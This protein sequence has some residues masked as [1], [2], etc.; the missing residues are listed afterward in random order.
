MTE[1]SDTALR[2]K[3][4]EWK[5]FFWVFAALLLLLNLGGAS[6]WGSEG[7]WAEIV[8]EMF[9]T[10]DFLHPRINWE[11][12]FDKPLVSYWFIAA[13]AWLNGGVV[14]EFLS[15]LPSSLAA[16]AALYG[17]LSIGR[18]LWDEKTAYRAGWI[19]LTAY[20]FSFWGRTAAADMENVAF[21]ILA[22]AWYL[23]RRERTDFLSYA[24]FWAICAVGGQTKGL[25]AIVLPAL[26]A[27][28]DMLVCGTWKRH[29]NVQAALAAIAGALVYFIP[30]ILERATR[31]GEY[32]SSGLSLVFREN[33]ERFFKPF[34]HNEPFYVYFIYVPQLFLPWTPLLLLAIAW[35]GKEWRR[36][37]NSERWLCLSA[38]ATFAIFTASGSRR[39]YYILP[40]LPFCALLCAVYFKADPEGWQRKA[41]EFL[42]KAFEILAVVAAALALALCLVWRPLTRKLG[43]E[44]PLILEPFFAIAG[45]GLLFIV[46]ALKLSASKRP[47]N[48]DRLMGIAI[49][50]CFA[51]IMSFG[52][53]LNE[54]FKLRTEK[55]FCQAIKPMVELTPLENM[56][57]YPKTPTDT[58]F[59]LARKGQIQVLKTPEELEAFLAKP[60]QAQ[61]ILIGERRYLD[62]LPEGLRER[63]AALPG[64]E[65]PCHPWER[66]NAKKKLVSKYIPGG[67]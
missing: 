5:A 29:L 15:R 20:S 58:A 9:V 38:L 64:D 62:K 14:T 49:A 44:F 18:S 51:L 26:I 11:P 43:F 61:G 34:D 45:V 66:R 46:Y 12:Y 27:G 30:F 4:P 16:L 23:H 60:R 6:L 54:V 59:Y 50:I 22:V 37:G 55:G 35:A 3:T 53:I 25:G 65:E 28:I 40:I 21:T 32:S 47:E 24:V 33:V 42:L 1:G 56:A 8:R 39:V 36:L 52:F 7:R 19:L 57:F 48:A 17:T 2:P 67:K 13:L 10:G 41:K 63:V 31:T